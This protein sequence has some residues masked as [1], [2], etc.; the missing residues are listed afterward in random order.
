[1]SSSY[2]IV[3]VQPINCF[4]HKAIIT[5]TIT[6]TQTHNNNKGYIDHRLVNNFMIK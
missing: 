6:I 3:D 2:K 5:I 4:N 1:M